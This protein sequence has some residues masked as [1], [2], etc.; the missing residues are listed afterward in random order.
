M[1]TRLVTVYV[2]VAGFFIGPGCFEL[3]SD[4]VP[5][6][7]ERAE[8]ERHVI[9][10][11]ARPDSGRIGTTVI[12]TCARFHPSWRYSVF[13]P[14]ANDAVYVDCES[15]GSLSSLVP[16]GAVS[17]PIS[18]PIGRQVAVSSGFRVA[19]LS[20]TLSIIV[21]PYDITPALTP[22]DSSILDWQGRHRAWVAEL[23]G[24]TVHI[25]RGYSTGDEAYEHHIKLLDGGLG[26]LPSIIS[27]WGVAIPDYP[28]TRVDT[29]RTGILKI[30]DWNTSEVMS[31]RFFGKPWSPHYL[32][33]G[34]VAFWVD[35]RR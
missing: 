11:S 33:N 18:V 13:F 28:G 1:K 30:Q 27:I 34:T 9:S 23:R 14:G 12:L 19:E 25:W 3:D 6:V 15:A 7:D 5:T 35:R 22:E 20:D 4:V 24:D 29:I 31:G 16:F 8:P 17:G 21:K 2:A 32:S 26:R 10:L